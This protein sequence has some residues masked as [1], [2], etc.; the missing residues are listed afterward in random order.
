M[1]EEPFTRDS[2]I[3]DDHVKIAISNLK[4]MWSDD[5][6]GNFKEIPIPQSVKDSGVLPEGY[7]VG[8]FPFNFN[9]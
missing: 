8:M 6:E 2:F 4:T 7:C 1:S 3:A 5:E 9:F